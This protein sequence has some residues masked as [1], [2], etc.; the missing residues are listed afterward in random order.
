MSYFARIGFK[1]DPTI[2]AFARARVSEPFTVF[3]SKQLY[4]SQALL[5]DDSQ[6]SGSGTTTTY[7]TNE[8]STTIAVG[9]STAGTRVRQTFRALNYQPGKSQMVLFT[10][11]VG[12]G[13]TGITKRWGQFNAKNGLFFEQAG[14]TLKIGRR[15]YTSGSAVDT[16]VSQSSWNIDKLDGTGSSGI[17]LDVTKTQIFVIDYEWLG[18]GR[19]RFGVVIN[20]LIYYVHQLLNANSLTLVYMQSPNLPLRCEI[21]NSG[22]GGANSFVHIC[23]AVSSEGGNNEIGFPRGITRG[24]TSI[25][26]NNDTNI[27]PI[28]GVR[29][30]STHLGA[31]V[32]ISSISV[33]CTSTTTYNVYVLLNPT[34]TGTA[35]SWSAVTN[36]A[37]E[38]NV[39]ATNATTL[40]GGTLLKTFTAQSTNEGSVQGGVSETF[41]L[42][43]NIAGTSDFV[44]L[45][46]QRVTGTT[47][48]FYGSMNI[49]EI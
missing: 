10:C 9:A 4:D 18:V 3:E 24:S 49:I 42:G 12:T 16:V 31:T 30:K 34:V 43:S 39:G 14:T 48:T 45:A 13:G 26:T 32:R 11:V 35:L 47:E 20:G 29:L 37:I 27:Y 41:A 17:T 28:V 2:D 23:S 46:V 21:T 6:T 8:S 7:N 44:M 22:A 5:W 19:V 1:D 38:E 25:Q 15:T 33:V 40:S 36:A